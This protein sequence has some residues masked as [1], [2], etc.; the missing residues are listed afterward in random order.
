MAGGKGTRL[1]P[2]THVLPKPLIPINKKTLIEHILDQL[3]FNGVNNVSLSI[4]YKSKTLISFLDEIK[5]KNFKINYFK[6]ERPLGTIGILGKINKKLKKNIL[7]T[8]CDT[9]IKYDYRKILNFHEKEKYAI[10]LVLAK[11]KQYLPY[12]VCNVKKSSNE[13]ISIKEKPHI[14]YLANTGFYFLDRKVAKY[15][16]KNK[17]YNFNELI[18][19]CLNNNEKIGT[20]TISENNWLDVGQWKEYQIALNKLKINSN[21]DK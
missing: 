11:K 7:I 15:I 10:T 20:F 13:L 12:G 3:K 2:F 5:K 14:T 6:E 21:N 4:N 19:K 16:P 17:F 8:N 1:L 18:Q 9:I